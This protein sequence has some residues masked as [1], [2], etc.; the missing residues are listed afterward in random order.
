MKKKILLTL[1]LSSSLATAVGTNIVPSTISTPVQAAIDNHGNTENGVVYANGQGA[2]VYHYVNGSY[3]VT[4]QQLAPY[5]GWKY[6]A[7]DHLNNQ[8]WYEVATN[9]WINSEQ[10]TTAKVVAN[11]GIAE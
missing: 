9:A 6:D 2:R 11:Q 10:A 8:T 5:S 7:V 3:Q 1:L 4:D